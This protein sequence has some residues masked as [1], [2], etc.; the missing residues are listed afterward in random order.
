MLHSPHGLHLHQGSHLILK[1]VHVR[2]NCLQMGSRGLF[3]IS[4]IKG[5]LL[6]ELCTPVKKDK[7]KESLWSAIWAVNKHTSDKIANLTSSCSIDL[8]PLSC[9]CPS[10]IFALIS[11]F[12]FVT[13]VWC[14]ENL[15]RLTV[16]DPCLNQEQLIPGRY[17]SRGRGHREHL[18]TRCSAVCQ[19]HL[20]D[21]THHRV[22]LC[23]LAWTAMCQAWQL[24]TKTHAHT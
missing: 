6:W 8:L 5:S 11:V 24:C 9:H 12:I 20:P 3:K 13:W 23:T 10:V 2:P 16:H 19:H 14:K 4:A 15:R 7:K 18:E 17:C 21:L 1:E 22:R